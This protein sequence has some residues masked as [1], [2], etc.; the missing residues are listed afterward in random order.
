LV[1]EP[2]PLLGPRIVLV[3]TGQPSGGRREAA[4]EH[5]P[6][7]RQEQPGRIR[8]GATPG[9]WGRLA[10][11]GESVK[12]HHPADKQTFLSSPLPTS[13]GSRCGNGESPG[14]AVRWPGLARLFLFMTTAHIATAH[15]QSVGQ[16]YISH[17]WSQWEAVQALPRVALWGHRLVGIILRV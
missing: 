15:P 7:R 11:P 17:V 9:P 4:N 3:A 12:K 10:R 14:S 16:A 6:E 13:V 8:V 2:P 5:D 1:P